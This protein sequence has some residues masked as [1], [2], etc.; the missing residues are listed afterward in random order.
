MSLQTTYKQLG[1]PCSLMQIQTYFASNIAKK[2]KDAFTD[3]FPD[4][5][6]ISNDE[7]GDKSQQCCNENTDID[8]K[9]LGSYNIL[10]TPVLVQ[11]RAFSK[12][13]G[14]G[15]RKASRMT[16]WYK[17]LS[18]EHQTHQD[19]IP[20]KLKPEY[21]RPERRFLNRYHPSNANK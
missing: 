7:S 16:S 12:Q 15:E 9:T 17:K 18:L 5:Q 4:I 10:Q 1:R 2:K 11:F 6:A 14:V 13:T 21:G 3:H 8:N 19:N 20:R